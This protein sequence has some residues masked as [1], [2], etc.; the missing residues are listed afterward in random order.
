MI[1]LPWCPKMMVREG[2]RVQLWLVRCLCNIFM[3]KGLFGTGNF[4]R[5]CVQIV[6][7]ML[8]SSINAVDIKSKRNIVFY[9]QMSAGT[10]L[11]PGDKPE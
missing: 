6:L 9:S 11:F 3:A 1:I 5:N 2:R 7:K 4:A 10:V 8:E